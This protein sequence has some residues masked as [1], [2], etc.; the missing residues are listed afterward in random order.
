MTILANMNPSQRAEFN[1]AIDPWATSRGMRPRA[2]RRVAIVG[3]SFF[4]RHTFN[5]VTS[6]VWD[7]VGLIGNRYLCHGELNWVRY[8]TRQAFDFDG[9][10]NYGIFGETNTQISARFAP[11]L[12]ANDASTIIRIVSVNASSDAAYYSESMA[13][14]AADVATAQAENRNLILLLPA[15]AGDA[16]FT[17]QRMSATKRVARARL[18]NDLRQL[19]G[20]GNVKGVDVLDMDPNYADQVSTLGDT[21]LLMT[22]EGLHPSTR[23]AYV[24]ALRYMEVF[25]KLYD[26]RLFSI[27]NNTDLYDATNNPQGAFGTTNPALDGTGGTVGT[28]GSGSLATGWTGGNGGDTAHS[29]TYSKVTGPNTGRPAQRCVFGGTSLAA[30]VDASIMFANIATVVGETYQVTV[31][32]DGWTNVSN[33]ATIRIA[34]IQD[35]GAFTNMGGDMDYSGTVGVAP[36]TVMDGALMTAPFKAVSTS[37]RI[38]LDARLLAGAPVTGTIDVLGIKPVRLA[39]A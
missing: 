38:R 21:N 29:R 33:I 10:S 15:T 8:L 11:A 37:T 27:A 36:A 17:G 28:G 26:K 7:P 2:N 3:D 19:Y 31:E 20:F 9:V 6:T 13:A 32:L 34:A 30:T 35:G 24:R 5:G 25:G 22:S 1:T 4:F 18:R 23:G 16:T 12:A 39:G 14:I